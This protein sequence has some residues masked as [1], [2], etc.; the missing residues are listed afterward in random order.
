MKT[1]RSTEL[2]A[3]LRSPRHRE[4]DAA[5]ARVDALPQTGRR[6]LVELGVSRPFAP[7]FQRLDE[8]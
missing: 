6:A 8:V 3:V 7:L 2:L 4:R 1:P 5:F